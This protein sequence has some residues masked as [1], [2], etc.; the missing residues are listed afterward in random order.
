MSTFVSIALGIQVLVVLLLARARSR[1]ARAVPSEGDYALVRRNPLREPAFVVVVVLVGVM[2]A[3][4][5]W[6]LRP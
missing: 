1:G 2:F 5:G 3:L 6:L 4:W